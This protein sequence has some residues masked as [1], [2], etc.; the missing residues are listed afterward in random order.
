MDGPSAGVALFCVLYS[1]LFNEPVNSN[2]AMTGEITIHGEVF[3]VGG[4]TEKILAA[5]EAGVK[6]VFIPQENMQ[7][8]YKTYDVEVIPVTNIGQI[9]ESIWEMP[10]IKKATQI[11][12]AN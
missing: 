1:S 6:R 8:L 2:V 5:Q 7:N 11:L 3:P 9:I 12:Y 10:P 4:V